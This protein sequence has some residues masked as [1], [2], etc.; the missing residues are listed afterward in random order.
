MYRDRRFL[1]TKHLVLQVCWVPIF[2]GKKLILAGDPMQLPP[3]ILSLDKHRKKDTQAK[4]SERPN[5]K[6]NLDSKGGTAKPSEPDK[7]DA[8][9]VDNRQEDAESS[10][11]TG[12]DS[13]SATVHGDVVIAEESTTPAPAP[14]ENPTEPSKQR[15]SKRPGLRPPRTL[16]T[17]LFDRLERM[18]GPGIKR[19]LNVQYRYVRNA[20]LSLWRYS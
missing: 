15:P 6:N 2:K 20:S 12:S 16:E 7:S 3:T 1:T 17:T 18:Y 10:S 8:S 19:L 13:D 11:E 14:P 9:S 5:G 4:S